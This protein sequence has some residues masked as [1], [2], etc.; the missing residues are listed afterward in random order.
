MCVCVSWCEGACITL[1]LSYCACAARVTVAVLCVCVCVSVCNVLREM[2]DVNVEVEVPTQYIYIYKWRVFLKNASFPRNG[3]VTIYYR[4]AI[5]SPHLQG[6]MVNKVHVICHVALWIK[7]FLVLLVAR[8][9]SSCSFDLLRNYQ[10][11]TFENVCVGGPTV[12]ILKRV[13]WWLLTDYRQKPNLDVKG[14]LIATTSTHTRRG[15]CTM[16]L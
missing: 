5:C 10:L 15:L 11:S 13:C 12:N 3:N 9:R 4:A 16:V 8:E 7:L 2:L 14:T 6:S 1:T